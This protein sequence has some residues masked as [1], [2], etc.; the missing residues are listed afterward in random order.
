MMTSLLGL[1]VAGFLCLLFSQTR[2]IGAM[3]MLAIIVL[4]PM[5]FLGVAA[6]GGLG[7]W[8]FTK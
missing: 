5:L 7:F 4:D 2:A 3:A 6:V 8:I 1:S